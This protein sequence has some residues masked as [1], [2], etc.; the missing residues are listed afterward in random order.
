MTDNL[1]RVASY[2]DI[3]GYILSL[4]YYRLTS[5]HPVG[6]NQSVSSIESS[7]LFTQGVPRACVIVG[8]PTDSSVPA[9]MSQ[10][11]KAHL[12]VIVVARHLTLLGFEHFSNIE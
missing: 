2:H 9:F 1:G 5:V 10:S 12:P 6:T 3:V 7:S 4:K 8:V 11:S